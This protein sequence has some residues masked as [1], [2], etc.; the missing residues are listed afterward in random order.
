MLNH[1]GVRLSVP[2]KIIEIGRWLLTHRGKW[3]VT[4][5]ESWKDELQK[6]Q[7]NVMKNDCIC[8]TAADPCVIHSL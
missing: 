2:W 6:Q 8:A 4:T 1:P 7:G 3:E 5:Q